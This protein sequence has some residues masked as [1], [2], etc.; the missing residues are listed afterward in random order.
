M[1]Y[2]VGL[3]R[4]I[5]TTGESELCFRPL[6]PPLESTLAVAWKKNQIFSRPAQKFL[7]M[8]G[9]ELSLQ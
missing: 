8:L 4:I 1:G 2:A 3:D 7:Q 9:D 5:N 6:D